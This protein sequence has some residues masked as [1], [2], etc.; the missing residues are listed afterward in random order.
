MRSNQGSQDMRCVNCNL[1]H[2][3]SDN[4]ML[5]RNN[6]TEVCNSTQE[7]ENHGAQLS[8]LY[9]KFHFE[10]VPKSKQSKHASHYTD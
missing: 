9:L 6:K 2:I 5:Y 4:N 8:I 7:F 3:F 10:D 1:V